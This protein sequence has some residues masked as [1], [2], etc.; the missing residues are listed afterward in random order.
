MSTEI[1]QTISDNETLSFNP[2]VTVAAVI[3]RDGRFLMVEEYSSEGRAV[4]NQPAGHLEADENLIEAAVRETLEET[5]WNI[6]I[7][8]LLNMNL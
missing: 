6:E 4:I 2:H 8:G 5:R 1:I 3:E 7:T